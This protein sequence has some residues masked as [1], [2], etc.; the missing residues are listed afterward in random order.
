MKGG[1]VKGTEFESW[2]G[3]EFSFLHVVQA[4]FGAHRAACPVGNAAGA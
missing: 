1:L 4:G 3:Q 2:E